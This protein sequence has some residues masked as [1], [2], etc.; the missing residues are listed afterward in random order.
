MELHPKIILGIV[1]GLLI[2]ILL[3]VMA[4]SLIALNNELFLLNNGQ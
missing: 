2:G 1:L 3:L 4:Q